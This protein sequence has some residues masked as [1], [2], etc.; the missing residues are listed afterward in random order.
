MRFRPFGHSF[1]R[2]PSDRNEKPRNYHKKSQG[3]RDPCLVYIHRTQVW[4]SGG[5]ISAVRWFSPCLFIWRPKVA[6]V[7]VTHLILSPLSLRV[8]HDRPYFNH[9]G[10]GCLCNFEAREQNN[11]LS[12]ANS[13]TYIMV[14]GI[15]VF[16]FVRGLVPSN[17]T[18]FLTNI[19]REPSWASW[20]TRDTIGLG[21]IGAL[22]PIKRCSWC[23]GDW[24]LTY[25]FVRGVC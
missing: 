1:R 4:W 12:G 11:L 23:A 22:R 13:R 10:F 9:L 5:R 17:D 16:V 7:T 24:S 6:R 25:M 20:R 19:G 14:L 2:N 3:P 8:L 21:K 15:D 18:K